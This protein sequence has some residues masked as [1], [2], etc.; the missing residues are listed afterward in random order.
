[1]PTGSN[2]IVH[3]LLTPAQADV[4][5][6]LVR[7]AEELAAAGGYD[8]VSMR[9]VA[10]LAGVSQATGYQYA[11]TKDQLLLEVLVRLGRDVTAFVATNAVTAGRPA[12]RMSVVFTKVLD[13]AAERPLLYQATYRAYVGVSPN[14]PGGVYDLVGFGPERVPWIG[15]TLRSGDLGGHTVERIAATERVLSCLFNGAMLSIAAGRHHREVSDTL[16]EA[17]HRMLP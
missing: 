7:A 5:D 1:M 6:R 13:A 16:T 9:E 15:D 2:Q 8:A 12:D 3:R 11:G 10:A 4:Q 17:V 14:M